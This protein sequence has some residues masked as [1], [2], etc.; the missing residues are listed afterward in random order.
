M[1]DLQHRSAL[2]DRIAPWI[3]VQ[4][5]P[6]MGGP[7]MGGAGTDGAAMQRSMYQS[8]A[9][10]ATTARPGRQSP[11]RARRG[12]GAARR[13]GSSRAT[14]SVPRGTTARKGQRREEVWEEM[15]EEGS[16]HGACLRETN[17]RKRNFNWFLVRSGVRFTPGMKQGLVVKQKQSALASIGSTMTEANGTKVEC[18]KG[19][20]PLQGHNQILTGTLFR[21]CATE[22]Y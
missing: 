8:S 12:R 2:K 11:C 1:L 4:A 13:G 9:P 22:P 7:V 21:W 16:V 10:R 15:R 6:E 19:L 18:T 14:R 17:T 20:L 5:G 3:T